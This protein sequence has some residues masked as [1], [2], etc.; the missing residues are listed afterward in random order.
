MPIFVTYVV[1]YA[2]LKDAPRVGKDL[3]IAG[4]TLYAVQFSDA[5]TELAFALEALPHEERNE[6][7]RKAQ[8]EEKSRS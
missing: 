7:W 2:D 6:P 5:L 1:K 8:I 4:G 3:Q